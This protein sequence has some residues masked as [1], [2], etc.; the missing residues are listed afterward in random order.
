M[1]DYASLLVCNQT[2]MDE[3]SYYFVIDQHLNNS[4]FSHSARLLHLM[5]EEGYL[6]L[7]DLAGLLRENS[8][9]LELMVE[10]D[11]KILDTW[12]EPF[13][14]SLDIWRKS[15]RSSTHQTFT[16]NDSVRLYLHEAGS[17]FGRSVMAVEGVKEALGSSR[18][19]RLKEYR[20]E[21]RRA[22][23]PYF[24]YIN[25]NLILSNQLGVGFH[26]WAD[27]QPF[28]AKKFLNLGI[29]QTETEKLSSGAQQLFKISFPE[30]A[31]HNPE[32]FMSVLTDRRVDDVRQMIS[33]SVQNSVSLDEEFARKA[34]LEVLQ[35]EHQVNH[36]RTIVSWATKPLDL[37]PWVGNLVSTAVDEGLGY[38]LERNLK[39]DY[40][41]FYLL[42]DVSRM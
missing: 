30:F 37:I 1:P 23:R 32:Q 25:A 33:H 12:I 13:K 8:S 3:E 22:L 31:I 9:L 5:F 41:W 28:Y 36:Y 15:W 27:F 4:Q 38:Y 34:L 42:S 2:I 18:K 6:K 16:P 7:V 21:L 24:L 11:L 29:T 19:R 35:I 39:R 20:D 14:Q 17:E 26:D 40:R 10:H